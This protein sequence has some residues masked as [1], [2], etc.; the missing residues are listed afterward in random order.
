[1]YV[2]VYIYIYI[3]YRPFGVGPAFLRSA[4]DLLDQSEA[5]DLLEVASEA[6]TDASWPAEV[7]E[8]ELDGEILIEELSGKKGLPDEGPY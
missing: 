3:M 2:Y 6:P 1:M 7:D 8:A 4:Q 5:E